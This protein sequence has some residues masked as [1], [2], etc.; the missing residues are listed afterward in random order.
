MMVSHGI[1]PA[2]LHP[3]R[4]A[5][6]FTASSAFG[7]SRP[8]APLPLDAEAT[9]RATSHRRGGRFRASET[10]ALITHPRFGRQR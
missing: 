7:S 10:A 4:F 1:D 9:A 2:A 3:R 6:T 8:C 5:R